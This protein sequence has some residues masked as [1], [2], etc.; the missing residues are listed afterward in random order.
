M[1]IHGRPHDAKQARDHLD[2]EDR[3][4]ERWRRLL[5]WW[6]RN[7]AGHEYEDGACRRCAG[8]IG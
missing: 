4:S 2:M 7:V 5:R 3:G 1:M 8:R 6:C